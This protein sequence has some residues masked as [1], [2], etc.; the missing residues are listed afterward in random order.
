MVKFTQDDVNTNRH[1]STSL[2]VD[3]PF[4]FVTCLA[5]AVFIPSVGRFTDDSPPVFP[6]VHRFKYDTDFQTIGLNHLR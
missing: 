6:V 1:S 5:L 2:S 4:V 3:N